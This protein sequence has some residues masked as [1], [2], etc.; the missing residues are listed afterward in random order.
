MATSQAQGP[1]VKPSVVELKSSVLDALAQVRATDTVHLQDE[2]LQSGGELEMDSIEAEAVIAILQ[3][4]FGR[5]LVKV[6]DL[7]PE[8]LATVNTVVELIHRRW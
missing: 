3:G 6:E 2:L 7:E 8:C 4:T 1:R 5:K